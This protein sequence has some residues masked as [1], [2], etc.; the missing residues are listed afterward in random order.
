MWNAAHQFE[1]AAEMAAAHRAKR[2]L[3]DAIG[4]D[5]PAQRPQV[6]R[7]DEQLR[8]FFFST[9]APLFIWILKAC[10]LMFALLILSFGSY[11]LIWGVIMRGLE[12]QSRPI[13]F[14]YSPGEALMPTGIVDLRSTK[15]APWVLTTC[16]EALGSSSLSGD[17]CANGVDG[18]DRSNDS[19]ILIPGQKY[20]LELTL[21]LP[22]SEVNRQLGVFM[23][24][25]DLKSGDRSLLAS[26]NQHSMFPYESSMVSLFRKAMLILPLASGL[27]S[28]TRAIT[29][30][31]FDNYVDS[32][33]KKPM[34][35]VEVSLGVPN[36]AVFPST[37]QSIQIHS[38]ELKYGKEMNAIQTFF[39]N[40]RYSCA[41]FGTG[42]LFMGYALIV[43]TRLYYRAQKNSWN[44]QPY[45][46]FFDSDG[47]S[48]H[49]SNSASHDRWTGADI[50]ILEDD[51]D[52][53]DAWEPINS[54]E[55]KDHSEEAGKNG[56][57]SKK[58][59]HNCVSDEES[60]SSEQNVSEDAQERDHQNT[61]FPLGTLA[62]DSKV[63]GHDPMFASRPNNGAKHK[64]DN[65]KKSAQEKEEKCLADM[66]MRGHSKWEVFTATNLSGLHPCVHHPALTH[67]SLAKANR[68]AKHRLR[69]KTMANTEGLTDEAVSSLLSLPTPEEEQRSVRPRQ[70]AAAPAGKA[71][72]KAPA[73]PRRSL[74]RREQMMELGEGETPAARVIRSSKAPKIHSASSMNKS[75]R[76]TDVPER[77][78]PAVQTSSSADAAEQSKPNES[79]QRGD[80]SDGNKTK[81]RP[82]FLSESIRERPAAGASF[83]RNTT[84]SSATGTIKKE[85]RFKQR[86][87]SK[88]GLG[89]PTV[90]GFPS[91]DIAPVGAFTR[92]GRPARVQEAPKALDGS[93]RGGSGSRYSRPKTNTSTK[94]PNAGNDVG[95]STDS[96]LANMS[97]EEIRDGVEEVQSILSAE[98]IEFLR[99]RGRQKVAKSKGLAVTKGTPRTNNH[100]VPPTADNSTILTKQEEIQLEEKNAYE[101]KE[102]MAELLSSVRTPEDMDR[103]YQEALQLG[104]AAELPSSSLSTGAEANDGGEGMSERLKN[105]HIATSL[106]RSTAPRQRLL[107]ARSLCDILEEDVNEVDEKRRTHSFSDSHDDRKSMKKVYPEL[108]PVAVRCLLDESVATFQTSGGRLLLNI[109]L[110]CIHSLMTLFVHPY[111]VVNINPSTLSCDDPFILYQTCFMS[112][113]SH[114]PPGTELYPPT[115]IKPLGEGDTNNACYRADSS[116]ATAESDSKA[117]YNDPAWTLLS[118]MRILPCLSDILLCLSTDYSIGSAISETTIQS[119]CG[120]VAMLTVRSPGAAGAIARHKG[121]LPF[122]VSYC[123]SPS[124]G[125]ASKENHE[126]ENRYGAE[127][128]DATGLFNT[129]AALPTLILLCCLARQSRD[130]AEL[131]MP[132]QAI[133]PDMQAI[134]CL[135]AENDK[136]LGIQIWSLVLLRILMRYGL[137]TEHIQMLINIAAPRVELMRPENKLG[138]HYLLLFANICDASKIIRQ[139]GNGNMPTITETDLAMSG[140][141]LSSSV[142]SCSNSF[143]S[144]V[145]GGDK[146]NMK[147][148]SAQLQLL[149]SYISTAAP[150]MGSISIPIVSNESCFEV[151][152]AAL[153][154]KMLDNALN[155]VLGRSFNAFWGTFNHQQVHS[156]EEESIACSF[157]SSFMEFVKAVGQPNA[158]SAL[159]KQIVNKIIDSLEQHSRRSHSP[160]SPVGN[161]FHP[162]RISWFVESEFSV[163]TFL[164]EESE[165]HDSIWHLLSTFAFSLVGRLNTGHEAMAA[166]IFC[167]EKLF[168]ARN[169]MNGME[170]SSHSLQTL[171]LRELSLDDRKL[172]S[173]HSSNIY[174]SHGLNTGSLN[175]LRCT[176]DF[177]GRSSSAEKFLLP[178]GGV[179][180]WNILS[181]TMNSQSVR[182]PSALHGDDHPDKELLD[183]VSHTLCLLLQLETA[184]NGSSY[185]SSINDGT[186]LYH[187]TNTCLFPD[188]IL[189]NDFIGSTLELLFR[190]F[191]G[192]SRSTMPGS[193]LVKDFVRACFQHSRLSKE[194]KES[195]KSKDDE[196]SRAEKKLL[197]MID[198]DVPLSDGYSKDELK[199]LDDFVD[200]MCNAYVEYAGQYA[201]CTYFIRFFLRHD[202]PAK[203]TTDML[204]KLHPILNLMTIED[205][206]RDV[207][208]FSLTQSLRGGLPSLD[209]SC[210]D[211]S[212]VLDSFSFSLKKKDKEL[213][214][215]DYVYLLAISVL[216]RNLASSSQRCDCG[217]Q[218]IKY[219]LSGVSDAVFYDVVMT[220]AKFLRSGSGTKDC[221]ISCVMD[222][223]LDGKNGLFEQDNDSQ[224]DWQWSSDETELWKRAV[225]SLKSISS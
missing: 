104:L 113:V 54:K 92:K 151:I 125:I 122:L 216:S 177:V 185:A 88:N 26:S 27:L 51:D 107:G 203:V 28:E 224:K 210:R 191:S 4:Y 48:A 31:C 91:L 78:N 168:Q 98:S 221:L 205:E 8:L 68:N 155:V 212:S 42:I 19:E 41:F 12:V 175:S 182:P 154:S 3:L 117:F 83:N 73:F 157:V 131:A 67:P 190:L 201:T 40:W 23:V 178:L 218:A 11:G 123:L 89:V 47:E 146:S 52:D 124:N 79:D 9:V 207:L 55:K 179:W 103:V 163:L 128:N 144:V 116:A 150:T 70:N 38:A 49:N 214:R 35:I 174:P 161:S 118:R 50:E 195:R 106:L 112:D 59:A 16:G 223:C 30:L 149:S 21:T 63:M 180:M 166:Y 80:S 32:H 158:G 77:D 1:R 183:F 20:F 181:S 5:E 13:F 162:A 135:E 64:I 211:P 198:P 90:G 164:C 141:W 137:A 2:A 100:D 143:Q 145:E 196:E 119:I 129:G 10:V 194:P 18:I 127:D 217:L 76:K 184:S 200:D 138:A 15:S 220:A 120:I 75:N 160:T 109:V 110:R 169:E 86:N 72:Q 101:G 53:S 22:E 65:E 93:Q 37:M 197:A 82:I 99:R 222:I 25:V 66:V 33:V 97:L 192:F 81:H 114:V 206:D 34:A 111:H 148:A 95:G 43:L 204:T 17:A 170:I 60:H 96:M 167:Q 133:I 87:R 187:I 39:R 61:T 186:K 132:F 136:E 45:A 14:D 46:D 24:K 71:K 193:I 44:S 213:C 165:G 57:S 188:E 56:H 29:L 36:P 134:L 189:S 176:A 140:V 94:I 152:E 105:L 108:L 159:K 126:S 6:P 171:F 62:N 7:F 130:I 74:A 173:N 153:G 209:S 147:L 156:L 142:R 139:N 84:P 202:F 225:N 85:S 208:L 69:R 115:Q 172:Q 199:A 58:P 102:K 215:N 121:L 219:R